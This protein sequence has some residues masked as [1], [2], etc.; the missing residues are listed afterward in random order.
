MLAAFQ[1]APSVELTDPS[2]GIADVPAFR[3]RLGLDR[4]LPRGATPGGREEERLRIALERTNGRSD[5]LP[6]AMLE[7][8]T[9]AGRA[10]CRV[11]LADG[12]NAT[13]F[14]VA[15]DLLL[16]NHHVF[17]SPEVA[18]E[19]ACVFGYELG[20]DRTP[21][22]AISF[23][24]DPVG[25]FIT[26]PEAERG[27]L[28]YTFV[29]IDPAA[30]RDF[31]HLRLGRGSSK[32]A[33]GDPM[34]LIHHPGGQ[35]K[36]VTIQ[37]NR[38]EEDKDVLFKYLS[39][40]EEGS[41]GAPVFNNSWDLVGLHM[42]A[43]AAPDGTVDARGERALYLNVAVKLSAVAADLERRAQEGPERESATTALAAFCDTDSLLGGYFGGL[44]RRAEEATPQ[45]QVATLYNHGGQDVDLGF[46]D[47]ARLASPEDPRVTEF[48]KL[49]GDLR[50]DVFVLVGCG[51]DVAEQVA[52]SLA[53]YGMPFAAGAMPAGGSGRPLSAVLW[54]EAT[55]ERRDV[56]W[57][58]DVAPFFRIMGGI[59][60]LE[61]IE[62]PLFDRAPE[63]FRFVLRGDTGAAV[64]VVPFWF[65]RDDSGSA[66]RQMATRA[67]ALALRKAVGEVTSIVVGGRFD[68]KVAA[69]ELPG[70]LGDGTS[71]LAVE[72]G[73]G[74]AVLVLKR[75][76]SPVGPVWL[77]PELAASAGAAELA[78]NAP[79]RP[80][81]ASLRGFSDYRPLL[82]RL[83]LGSPD[84]TALGEQ[85]AAASPELLAALLGAA[86]QQPSQDAASE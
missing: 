30:A 76:G 80:A 46:L 41:S 84:L 82:L 54:N 81:A 72:D 37:D 40:A 70:G 64:D 27:G 31:G 59:P 36:S 8:G 3:A 7:L 21:R 51:L 52:R 29:R 33:R 48:A 67:L 66:R 71:A 13:G 62:G 10:V 1:R 14:L 68:G 55:V 32:V 18:R 65:E 50:L 12:G 74:G 53:E 5:I 78:A 86:K 77:P 26:S 57:P 45:A 44:G 22:A 4:R 69:A 28:D 35:R 16:T 24:P 2:I 20:P 23:R 43:M 19:A 25:L 83:S 61:G 15:K 38:L 75:P 39:D 6:Y 63:R 56:G 58:A 11:E 42:G 17:P 85:P 49:L 60:G 73:A 9:K 47:A 79:A 34:N